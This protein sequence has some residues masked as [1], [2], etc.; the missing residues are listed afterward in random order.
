MVV[1]LSIREC[2]KSFVMQ[3]ESKDGMG[4]DPYCEELR[5]HPMADGKY[6]QACAVMRG[7]GLIS[8]TDFKRRVSLALD[9]LRGHALRPFHVG[10]CWGLGFSWRSLPS[11][12]PFLITTGIIGRGLF[13]CARVGESSEALKVM[14][15]DSMQCLELWFQEWSVRVDEIGVS[16]PVYSPGIREPIYNAASYAMAAHLLWQRTQSGSISRDTSIPL[17]LEKIRSAHLKGLG[18]TYAPGNLVVD[19][20][21]QCYILNALAD[22]HGGSLV[23]EFA[24]EMVGQFAT[25]EGFADALRLLPLG[26]KAGQSRDIPWLRPF[27]KGSVELLPKVA[28]LWSLGELLVL[29]SHLACDGVRRDGWVSLGARAARLIMSILTSPDA[30][31]AKYPRHV[32]HAVHG[33]SCYLSVLRR[34]SQLDRL[35]GSS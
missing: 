30:V 35:E 28:R 8:A 20:L 14:L 33:L 21:H 34:R 5:Y 15:K 23:E 13:D 10:S 31:E 29:V 18:W 11:Q 7:T 19:L 9:R 24:L 4:L 2:I 1:S 16:L 12:E 25:P 22:I 6:L 26:G 27:D 3:Y 32:M 17:K